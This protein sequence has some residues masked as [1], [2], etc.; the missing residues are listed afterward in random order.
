MSYLKLSDDQKQIQ[1][2]ASD[3]A[4]NEI[5]PHAKKIDNDGQFSDAL[6]KQAWELGFINAQLPESIGGLGLKTWDNTV[7]LEEL[8]SASPAFAMS[9]ACSAAAQIPLTLFGNEQQHS[10]FLKPLIDRPLLA[11]LVG[12]CLWQESSTLTAVK[13]ADGYVLHGKD[14]PVYNASLSE[15]YYACCDVTGGGKI[16]LII[17]AKGLT[18]TSNQESFG[19]KSFAIKLADFADVFVDDSYVVGKSDQ[20]I[21]IATMVAVH[22]YVLMSAICIGIARA[23]LKHAIRYS[24]ER[25]TFGK[26]IA[27]H[28]AVAFMLADLAKD[29]EAARLL[30]WKAARLADLKENGNEAA[31]E[32]FAFA[33]N[34][35]MDAAVNAVQ[36]F[37][38][39]GYSREYPVEVLM[40]DAKSI[41]LLY[42]SPQKVA[43]SIGL[44]LLTH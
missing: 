1:K 8:A 15:W 7:I 3:F 40:R 43:I 32:A 37:G 30:A 44:S 5:G 4:A 38:G 21:Q 36:I 42:S 25:Q 26:P 13:V 19:L 20:A 31:L 11:G 17:P 16:N 28:Q 35:S 22:S 9:I 6:L 2:L 29:T 24:N 12:N 27:Q 33:Q 39:Y 18:F 41:Q 34:A 10:R 14:I 23:A